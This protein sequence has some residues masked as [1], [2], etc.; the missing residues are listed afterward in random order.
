MSSNNL[1]MSK[2]KS[3]GRTRNKARAKVHNEDITQAILHGTSS[4]D[5]N[6]LPNTPDASKPSNNIRPLTVTPTTANLS[7][8]V[9]PDATILAQI[10]Q[11]ETVKTSEKLLEY[12][13][14]HGKCEH[15]LRRL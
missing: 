9:L 6:M 3:D 10:N 5:T 8:T 7:A 2:R 11:Y 12:E 14:R 4:Q 13:S 15:S 1:K